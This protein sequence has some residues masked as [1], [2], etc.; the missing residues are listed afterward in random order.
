MP[1]L[2]A[3]LDQFEYPLQPDIAVAVI[4]F[5]EDHPDQ[6]EE[7]L[8]ALHETQFWKQRYG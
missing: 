1:T 3:G 6:S 4:G 5:C 8:A 2:I 7:I